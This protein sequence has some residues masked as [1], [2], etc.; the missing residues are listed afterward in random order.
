MNQNSTKTDTSTVP[1]IAQSLKASEPLLLPEGL[2]ADR[3][4]ERGGFPGQCRAQK[5]GGD[6]M[7]TSVWFVSVV[8]PAGMRKMLV[9]GPELS[10]KLTCIISASIGPY[11]LNSG[12][13][14]WVFHVTPAVRQLR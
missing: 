9:L 4:E 12:V 10:G 1:S 7:I 13:L 14:R 5:V 8:R 6:F 11:I 2:S 3:S